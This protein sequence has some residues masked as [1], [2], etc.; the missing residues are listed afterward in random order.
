MIYGPNEMNNVD[1]T[2]LLVKRLVNA[3]HVDA[4]SLPCPHAA[5]A[6]APLTVAELSVHRPL[7]VI[8]QQVVSNK[9][10]DWSKTLNSAD[11]SKHS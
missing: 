9:R 5:Q 8:V 6:S 1:Q 3:G 2:T 7:S 10:S 11:D 4:S